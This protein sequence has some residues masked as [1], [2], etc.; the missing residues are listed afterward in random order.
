VNARSADRMGLAF[1]D[2]TMSSAPLTSN[3][4][5][6]SFRFVRRLLQSRTYLEPAQWRARRRRMPLQ[7]RVEVVPDL[8]PT[9]GVE[10]EDRQHRDQTPLLQRRDRR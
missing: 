8:Y 1:D 9:I 6:S 4:G 5:L 2:T 10:D 7:Y 3:E